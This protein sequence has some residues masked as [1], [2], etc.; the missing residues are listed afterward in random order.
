VAAYSF[1]LSQPVRD[2]LDR[3]HRGGVRLVERLFASAS[4][5]VVEIQPSAVAAS[6][7]PYSWLL[8]RIAIQ[9]ITLTSA[10]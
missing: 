3:L 1:G 4:E 2:L 9:G 6:V 8:R 7:S 5:D 10:G